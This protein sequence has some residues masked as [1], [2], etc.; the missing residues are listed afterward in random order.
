MAVKIQQVFV[1]I[2]EYKIKTDAE[3]INLLIYAAG[4]K[5][6]QLKVEKS[7]N[8]EKVDMAL[9]KYF[10]QTFFNNFKKN[11]RDEEGHLK[12]VVLI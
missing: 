6:E 12:P 9:N 11:M 7:G 8:F 1:A 3:K 2:R 5:A 4:E 10:S